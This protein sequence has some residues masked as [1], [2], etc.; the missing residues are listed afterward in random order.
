MNLTETQKKLEKKM[1][2]NFP[3]IWPNEVIF[4]P[5]MAKF[6]QYWQKMTYFEEI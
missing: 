4:D 2:T 3:N 6:W 1:F 5:E